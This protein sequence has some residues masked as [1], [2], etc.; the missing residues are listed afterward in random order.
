M[1]PVATHSL[2]TMHKHYNINIY[3]MY[4]IIAKQE[5]PAKFDE[6]APT[7]PVVVVTLIYC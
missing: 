3:F 4:F 5:Q 1:K 6:I 7:M 2:S